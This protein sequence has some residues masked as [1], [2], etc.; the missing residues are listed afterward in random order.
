MVVK[1]TPPISL[2][3]EQLHAVFRATEVLEPYRRSA[4]LVALAELLRAEP[5]PIGDGS[6]G[7][8]IR[9]LQH[10]FR[11]PMSVALRSTPHPPRRVLGA[12]I[13]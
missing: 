6:V 13:E 4:F 7:R 9:Q 3:D 10:E 5:R 1:P 2:T 8:A 11:D 12:A